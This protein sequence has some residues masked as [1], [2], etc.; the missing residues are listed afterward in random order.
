MAAL[1]ELRK[2]SGLTQVDL[3]AK[4]RVTQGCVSQWENGRAFPRTE[5]LP[6]L[7]QLLGCTAKELL[8]AFSA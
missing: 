8:Q 2:R 6:E 7:A 3:A 5:R 4:M 1:K